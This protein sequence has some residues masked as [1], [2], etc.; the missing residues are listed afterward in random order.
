MLHLAKRATRLAPRGRRALAARVPVAERTVARELPDP[1]SDKKK[2]RR[3]F[4]VYGLG[5]FASC[6]VIFNYEKTSLP[7]VNAV[8]YC[9]RRCDAAKAQLGPNIGFAS[10]WPWI[11]GP[12]NTVKGD[13]DI[14]FDVAGE[15]GAGTLKLK[16]LRTS[17]LVPFDIHSWTLEV[18]GGETVDLVGEGL[19]FDM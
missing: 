9:L 13:I 15:K 3:Y 2:N 19:Q 4:W 17:K 14:A 10:T 18:H 1:F 7:I 6:A 16:A 11:W 5:V 8:L 12:L